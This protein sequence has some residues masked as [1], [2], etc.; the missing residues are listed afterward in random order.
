MKLLVCVSF[1]VQTIQQSLELSDTKDPILD[2][3]SLVILTRFH[4]K[5]N[6]CNKYIIPTTMNFFQL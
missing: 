3:G 1:H 6:I 4:C 2:I 5:Q